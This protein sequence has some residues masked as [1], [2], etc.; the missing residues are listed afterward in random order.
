MRLCNGVTVRS[1]PSPRTYRWLIAAFAVLF[2]LLQGMNLAHAAEHGSEHSHDG[3]SCEMVLLTEEHVDV[4]P[5]P[6]AP[7]P[8][9]VR[10]APVHVSVPR[11]LPHRGLGVVR[12]PPS[13][14]PPTHSR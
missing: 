5:S 14:G 6:P 10:P 12:A 2:L 8:P 3:V 4:A 7:A 13:R 9:V 1:V 11:T